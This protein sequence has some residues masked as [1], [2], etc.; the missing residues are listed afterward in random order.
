MWRL[1][2]NERGIESTPRHPVGPLQRGSPCGG[3]EV[4]DTNTRDDVGDSVP[5]SG[6][7]H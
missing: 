6:I 7:G 2:V 3:R 5:G 1:A 4:K